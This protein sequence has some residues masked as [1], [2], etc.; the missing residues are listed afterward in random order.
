MKGRLGTNKHELSRQ[1]SVAWTSA[2]SSEHLHLYIS[3]SFQEPGCLYD[4]PIEDSSHRVVLSWFQ[5]LIYNILSPGDAWLPDN[6]LLTK[7]NWR[8]PLNYSRCWEN[9]YTK[10]INQR[11][12]IYTLQLWDNYTRQ[13]LQSNT[14]KY[15]LQWG[16]LENLEKLNHGFI[17]Q[18]RRL[19]CEHRISV[20]R[21]RKV[22]RIIM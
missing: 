16:V 3:I 13:I 15:S 6:K 7:Q 18:N 1:C 20:N 2:C 11:N 4:M 9:N 8:L 5:R 10:Q 14:G 22:N 19:H 12:Q 21:I 17:S